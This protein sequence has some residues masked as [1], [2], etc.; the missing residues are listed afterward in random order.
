MRGLLSRAWLRVVDAARYGHPARA[1]DCQ[2]GP[3]HRREKAG[4]AKTTAEL[5]AGGDFSEVE[6]TNAFTSTVRT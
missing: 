5:V 3:A 1:R 6:C 2:A 4:E